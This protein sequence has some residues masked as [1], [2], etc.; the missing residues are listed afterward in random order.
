MIIGIIAGFARVMMVADC[1]RWTKSADYESG[2]QEFESLRA[3]HEINDLAHH[4][5]PQKA[6]G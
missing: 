1:F 4:D 3:R 6:P 5:L 2:G